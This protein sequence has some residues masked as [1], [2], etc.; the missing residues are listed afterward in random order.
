[1][2]NKESAGREWL[3]VREW[4]QDRCPNIVTLQKTGLEEHFPTKDLREIGF[5]SK[6]LGGLRSYLEALQGLL[7]EGPP[8]DDH[9][10]DPR[11]ALSIAELSGNAKRIGDA[12]YRL[13]RVEQAHREALRC[14]DN[15]QRRQA[16]A[17]RR[18]QE[19]AC[20]GREKWGGGE[21]AIFPDSGSRRAE[22]ASAARKGTEPCFP[23]HC[24]PKSRSDWTPWSKPPAVPRIPC[25]EYALAGPGSARRR[26]PGGPLAE[27]RYFA[28]QCNM[29]SGRGQACRSSTPGEIRLAL[30]AILRAALWSSALG[31][32][33]PGV[34]VDA[35]A[36]VATGFED[37]ELAKLA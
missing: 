2:K 36:S 26:L 17:R 25:R 9:V 37:A 12:R 14:R 7:A 16:E 28:L 22:P 20:R 3:K 24:L 31:R 15:R 33:L 11:A 30:V 32:C 19:R 1:M 21:D 23:S 35:E 18:A 4:L 27:A 10:A 8:P 6:Y 29:V 5:E 13:S 34:P